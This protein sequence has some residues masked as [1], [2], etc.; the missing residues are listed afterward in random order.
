MEKQIEK[1]IIAVLKEIHDDLV[2][3]KSSIDDMKER[4]I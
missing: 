1:Q 4:K 3:I 2:N